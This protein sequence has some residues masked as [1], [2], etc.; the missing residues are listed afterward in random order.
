MAKYPLDFTGRLMQAA[1]G[2]LRALAKEKPEEGQ[3]W[4]E[5]L[6]VPRAW[7]LSVLLSFWY[8]G[9]V[10]NEPLYRRAIVDLADTGAG[11]SGFYTIWTIFESQR[12]LFERP[13]ELA[14]MGDLTRS[15][16]GLKY[17]ASTLGL[18]AMRKA[19]ESF[20]FRNAEKLI[21]E[22]VPMQFEA[23]AQ[24]LRVPEPELTSDEA[25]RV[26]LTSRGVPAALAAQLCEGK[27][28]A[29]APFIYRR[30]H[31]EEV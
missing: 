1:Q 6:T 7:A 17:A 2:A 15:S 23:T 8:V 29:A 14:Y 26:Y 13:A 4:A 3:K 10:R 16:G 18:D 11:A 28:D 12:Q 31:D 20:Y 21:A 24:A 22:E 5:L 9:R 27:A 19:L 30:E 25:C